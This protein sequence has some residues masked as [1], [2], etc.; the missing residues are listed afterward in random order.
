M[1]VV[2]VAIVAVAAGC[3]GLTQSEN[4]LENAVNQVRTAAGRPAFKANDALNHRARWWAQQLAAQETLK[5]SDI[6]NMPIG[7]TKVGE[8]VAAG[9]SIEAAHAALKASPGHYAN[10][11]DPAFVYVGVGATRGADG[12]VYAVEEFVRP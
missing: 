6:T 8:N 11:V 4:Y 12:L 7:W 9:P 10:M 5:H 1:L 3:N 2:A